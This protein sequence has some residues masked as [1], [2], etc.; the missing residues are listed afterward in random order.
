MA[1]A[2]EKP[3]A[4]GTRFDSLRITRPYGACKPRP[5]CAV[6]EVRDLLLWE[7]N[8]ELAGHRVSPVRAPST[9]M[10]P[11]QVPTKPADQAQV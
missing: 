3:M 4:I 5:I 2:A 7:Q 11:S 1:V 6:A 9:S 10:A 8:T